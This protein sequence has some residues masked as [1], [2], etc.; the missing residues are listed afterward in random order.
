MNCE[1]CGC[2]MELE[3]RNGYSVWVC[4]VC[5]NQSEVEDGE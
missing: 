4:E 3:K 1:N 2:S 5:D